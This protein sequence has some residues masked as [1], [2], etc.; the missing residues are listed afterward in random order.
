MEPGGLL[1]LLTDG[2][3][4]AH[5]PD[6]SLFGA[7]RALDVVRAHRQQPAHEIVAALHSAVREFS[8][9]KPIQD[10]I[11]AIIIKSQPAP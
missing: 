6:N 3:L 1:L 9:H 10:D 7:T 4:E 5:A 11:T 2:I 8:Q